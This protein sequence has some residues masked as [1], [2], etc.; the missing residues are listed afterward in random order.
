MTGKTCISYDSF[1]VQL[2]RGGKDKHRLPSGSCPVQPQSCTEQLHWCSSGLVHHS[3]AVLV[4]HSPHLI[5]ILPAGLEQLP[6]GQDSAV[7]SYT[8]KG[9][10][11][12]S[13][14]FNV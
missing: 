5:Q 13:F 8:W 7:I 1:G 14:S 12:W 9:L 11:S 4:Y 2:Q 6:S 3:Q 10:T